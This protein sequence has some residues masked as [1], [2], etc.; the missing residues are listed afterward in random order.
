AP[1]VDGHSFS[2]QDAANS[3]RGGGSHSGVLGEGAEDG[4]RQG[5][6]HRRGLDHIGG[7][8]ALPDTGL[9]AAVGQ[10]GWAT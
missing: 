2:T 9:I 1:G 10:W 7:F 4:S 6:H 3:S 8:L 5:D